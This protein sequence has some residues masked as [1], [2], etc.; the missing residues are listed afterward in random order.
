MRVWE[1]S[2]RGQE[3]SQGGNTRHENGRLTTVLCTFQTPCRLHR[4]PKRAIALNLSSC[5]QKTDGTLGHAMA[6][7]A[8]LP[9]QSTHTGVR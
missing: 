3:G 8:M 1:R 6:C 4:E 7:D 2:D 5:R 9:D